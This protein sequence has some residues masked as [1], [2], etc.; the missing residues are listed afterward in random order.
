MGSKFLVREFFMY[1]KKKFEGDKKLYDD[2]LHI[3][4]QAKL[5]HNFNLL[6]MHADNMFFVEQ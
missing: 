3:N 4:T 5:T 2:L 6:A 1:Q